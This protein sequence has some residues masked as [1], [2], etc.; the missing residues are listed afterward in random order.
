MT[1]K[2]EID[3][4]WGF[5]IPHTLGWKNADNPCVRTSRRKVTT[6]WES[7]KRYEKS[8][9]GETYTVE[10]FLTRIELDIQARARMRKEE[11]KAGS[12][13][14]PVGLP[15][16]LNEG[17]WEDDTMCSISEIR[18]KRPAIKVARILTDVEKTKNQKAAKEAM[19][20]AR[21]KLR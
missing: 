14:Q 5:C 8:Q 12:V 2:E 15:V 1:N 6:A 21:E 19:D 16:Y 11:R 10:G 17:R 3:T 13:S 7:A 9:V 18:E 4:L 20:E